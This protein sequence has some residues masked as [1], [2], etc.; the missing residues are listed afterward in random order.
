MEAKKILLLLSIG[1]AILVPWYLKYRKSFSFGLTREKCD[2]SELS[3]IKMDSDRSKLN[4]CNYDE[5]DNLVKILKNY[6]PDLQFI[7]MLPEDEQYKVYDQL[8]KNYVVDPYLIKE[9]IAQEK[10]D[11]KIDY[12]K[13]HDLY[14]KIMDNNFHMSIFQKEMAKDVFIDDSFAEEY[15]NNNKKT[16]FSVQPFVK[17]VPGINARIVAMEDLKKTNREYETQLFQNKNV[18]PIDGFN[19]NTMKTTDSALSEALISMKIGEYKVIEIQKGQKFMIYKVSENA[20]SWHDYQLIAAQ[21]KSVLKKEAIEKK[22][23]DKIK[24]LSDVIKVKICESGL[25]NFIK[26]KNK[27]NEK[28]NLSLKDNLASSED[29]E[30]INEVAIKNVDQLPAEVK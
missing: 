20:G 19:P 30:N 8:L 11:K 22:C 13:D 4:I 16:V 15:Y 1:I 7:H 3:L 26:E 12:L 28:L 2:T 24:E 14:M 10:I 6:I 18:I 25:K 29:E 23:T 27:N 5:F 17:E 9:F 21:V